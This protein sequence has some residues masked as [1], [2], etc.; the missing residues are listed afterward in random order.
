MSTGQSAEGPVHI[1]DMV[2]GHA[3]CLSAQTAA[4]HA[5]PG[6]VLYLHLPR[7]GVY[8]GKSEYSN[9]R[10][11]ACPGHCAWPGAANVRGRACGW[12]AG[13]GADV[14]AAAGHA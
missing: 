10:H 2:M 1:C 5:G 14:K 6:S 12:C 13:R 4:V 11:C 3:S 8:Y 9:R 7:Y